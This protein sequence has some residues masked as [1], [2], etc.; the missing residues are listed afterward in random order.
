MKSF[1]QAVSAAGEVHS[2]PKVIIGDTVRF[3]VTQLVYEVELEACKRHLIGC[4][5]MQKNDP[6]LTT[7]SLKSKLDSLWTHLH[8]WSVTPLGRGCFEFQFGLVEDMRKVWAQGVVNMKPGFLRF[9]CW[10]KDFNVMNQTQT[11]AQIWVRLIH[12]PQ[13]YWHQQTF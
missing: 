12:L 5:T 8:N 1:A 10:S 4:V 9:Y 6:P 13:E 11:H 7:K 3:K 2:P